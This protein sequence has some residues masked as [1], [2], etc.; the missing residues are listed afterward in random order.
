MIEENNNYLAYL[1]G[2]LDERGADMY[3]RH[4]IFALMT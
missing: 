3:E 4:K 2:K 1:L